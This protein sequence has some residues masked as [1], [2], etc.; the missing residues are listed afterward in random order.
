MIQIV[1]ML[2]LPPVAGIVSLA[3][4]FLMLYCLAQFINVLHSFESLL[5]AI[6]VF[7]VAVVAIGIVLAVVLSFLG[8]TLATVPA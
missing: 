6:G 2:I 3:G 7:I 5:K 4:V 1:T 8:V